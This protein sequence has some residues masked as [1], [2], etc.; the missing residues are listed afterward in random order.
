M[1]IPSCQISISWEREAPQ[2]GGRG[3]KLNMY[4]YCTACSLSFPKHLSPFFPPIDISPY[5]FFFRCYAPYDGRSVYTYLPIGYI[6]K[7]SVR[8]GV[9][10]TEART[11]GEREKKSKVS[12]FAFADWRGYVGEG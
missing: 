7:A 10:S 9:K 2:E 1:R 3:L 8:S 4:E 11:V 12:N 5:F 6:S